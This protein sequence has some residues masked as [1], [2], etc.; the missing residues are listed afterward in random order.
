MAAPHDNPTPT[1]AATAADL[2]LATLRELLN[3]D[4]AAVRDILRVFRD[5]TQE[6]ADKVAALLG[7][8]EAEAARLILHRLKGS[9]SNV[10]AVTLHAAAQAL[11][12]ELKGGAWSEAALSAFLEA[13][14]RTQLA[15]SGY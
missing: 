13:Q 2:Q 12:A 9:S 3:G 8:G 5:D 6:M 11:E 15:L 1:P 4:E 14:R 7:A 10:G